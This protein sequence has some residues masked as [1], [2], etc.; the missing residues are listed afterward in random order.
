M[1][2]RDT[3]EGNS[4]PDNIYKAF[5]D[6]SVEG[7][8][9]TTVG[10]QYLVANPTLAKIYGYPSPESLIADFTNI[11]SELY[12]KPER[13]VS[14]ID[15]I[16]KN[17][18]VREFESEIK[19]KDGSTIWISENARGIFKNNE[20]IGFEGTVV[21][22]TNRKYALEALEIQQAYFR[23]LFHN[24]PQ[25]IVLI[26]EQRCIVDV[27]KAFEKLFCVNARNI[28]GRPNRDII[29]PPEQLDESQAFTNAVFSGKAIERETYRLNSSGVRVPVSVL[30]YPIIF[31]E[32]VCGV[33]YIYSDIS[34]R[35]EF[36]AKLSHQ[37]F[38]DP[39]TG[40]PNRTLFKERLQQAIKRSGRRKNFKY[41]VLLLDIDDFK[42]INDSLG[43]PAGDAFLIKMAKRIQATVRDMDTVAR[44]GGDEFGIILEEI[45]SNKE[46]IAIAKRI[47]STINQPM[48][49]HEACIKT[50]ASIGMV[51][52]TN[53]YQCGD[54]LTRD[55]DIAM[56]K[57]KEAG[58]G[59][60]K[61][62]TGKMHQMV[63]EEI[64]LE[65]A[66][67]HALDNEEFTL[68][69]Q[70][71]YH[72]SGARISG[73][74]SLLR[75]TTPTIGAVSPVQFIPMAEENG[76]IVP[77]GKWV[78]E[79][80]CKKMVRWQET[81]PN[82]KDAY[83]SVNISGRQLMQPSFVH[84]VRK[85]LEETNLAPTCLQ[86]EITETSVMSNAQYAVHTLRKL[87]DLGLRI[88]IDDFGTGYS[89]LSYLQS[90]PIDGLKIDKSFISGGETEKI[91]SEIVDTILALAKSLGIDVVAEGVETS[92]QLTALQQTQAIQ[93]Q[94]FLLSRPVAEKD[95]LLH[96]KKNYSV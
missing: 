17:G 53:A 16:I 94:G 39:L 12:A 4:I 41:A 9:R 70:P 60:F 55:A 75:W 64:K 40:L 13:R 87:K 48:E 10:G 96:F 50:S 15:Q 68:F 57:A 49:T 88:V 22:I 46:A 3:L 52:Q 28:V 95:L 61:V 76:L 72:Q 90:F 18:F 56:Y 6:N 30:G 58:K 44:L 45:S 89:S 34:Q 21:D 66:L 5:F 1:N 77:I 33:Y 54:D 31:N 43:H 91:N 42:R 29:V 62:F 83:V 26:D 35:K 71:I 8:F 74:E 86:L 11:A 47:V 14:F 79:E 92:G 32:K 84:T 93:L 20:L 65:R 81:W 38:H 27:N 80:S 19:R 37:A 24:S 63:N 69:F 51:T 78:L 67:T 73:L 2:N 85:I 25:A 23:Q 36:E 59:R 7:I 82:L